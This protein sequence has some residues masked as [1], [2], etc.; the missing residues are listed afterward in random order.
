MSNRTDEL[1]TVVKL[2]NCLIIEIVRSTTATR[3]L[4]PKTEY[5]K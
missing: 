4:P 1:V 2:V 5:G 3:R